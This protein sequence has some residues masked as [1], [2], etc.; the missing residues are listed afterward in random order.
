[1]EYQGFT[2]LVFLCLIGGVGIGLMFAY[3]KY[4]DYKDYTYAN[5]AESM[6]KAFFALLG[7]LYYPLLGIILCVVFVLIITLFIQLSINISDLIS[8]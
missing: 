7:F 5:I 8:L 2:V 3:G 4:N 1:M 6:R